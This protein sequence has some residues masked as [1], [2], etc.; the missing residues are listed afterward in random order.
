MPYKTRGINGMS[1]ELM[2]ASG[3]VASPS[4]RTTAIRS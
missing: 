4:A 1:G 2:V 3:T